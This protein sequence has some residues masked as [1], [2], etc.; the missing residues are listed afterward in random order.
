VSWANPLLLSTAGIGADSQTDSDCC[1]SLSGSVFP[2]E[3]LETKQRKREREQ[4]LRTS[5]A[6]AGL[7]TH[8]E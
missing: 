3:V 1:P 2:I 7:Q 5:E 8:A 4:S 6:S